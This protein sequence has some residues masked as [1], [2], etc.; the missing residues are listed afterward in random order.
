MAEDDYRM[1]KGQVYKDSYMMRLSVKDRLGVWAKWVTVNEVLGLA[2]ELPYAYDELDKKMIGEVSPVVKW[3]R[4]EF[5][6]DVSEFEYTGGTFGE[7]V[8]AYGQPVGQP[9]AYDIVSQS[10]SV[11]PS[12]ITITS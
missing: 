12:N 2:I 3:D 11:E 4:S 8:D 5:Q 9:N 7:E 10:R 1:L 6:K